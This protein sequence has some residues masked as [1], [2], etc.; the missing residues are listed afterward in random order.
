MESIADKEATGLGSLEVNWFHCVWA[1]WGHCNKAPKTTEASC[2]AVLEA[3]RPKP[4]LQSRQ[5]CFFLEALRG[6]L[7]HASL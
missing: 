4:K 2:L 6:S 1:S 5:G 7:S 3:R